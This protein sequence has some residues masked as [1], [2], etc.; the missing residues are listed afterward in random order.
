MNTLPPS[1]GTKLKI[2]VSADLGNNLHL[3]DVDFDCVFYNSIGKKQ[4]LHKS[5]L[6]E[7][8]AD[9]YVAV[10]DT[11]SIGSGEYYLKLTVY[12]PDADCADGKRTEVVDIPTGV[13]VRG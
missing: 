4:L 3:K 8:D 9:N 5:N 7:Y 1:L 12:I 2:N 11:K 10:V 6:I 13:K